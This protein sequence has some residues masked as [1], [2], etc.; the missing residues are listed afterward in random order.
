MA[1]IRQKLRIVI[2]KYWDLI[3]IEWLYDMYKSEVLK[4]ESSKELSDFN[5]KSVTWSFYYWIQ[6]IEEWRID[7]EEAL[8]N[9]RKSLFFKNQ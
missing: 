7:K 5:V 3:W 6:E 2:E 1:K 8:N 4:I 9:M